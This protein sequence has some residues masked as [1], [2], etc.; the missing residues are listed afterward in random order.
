M[1]EGLKMRKNFPCLTTKW[2]TFPDTVQKCFNHI[3]EPHGA[4]LGITT[5]NRR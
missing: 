4:I 1:L 3:S 2:G 5:Y